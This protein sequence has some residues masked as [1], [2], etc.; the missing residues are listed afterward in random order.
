MTQAQNKAWTKEF[1]KAQAAHRNCFKFAQEGNED[2]ANFWMEWFVAHK[3]Q[4]KRIEAGNFNSAAS[5]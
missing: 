4:C 1:K 5:W 2:E 3:E